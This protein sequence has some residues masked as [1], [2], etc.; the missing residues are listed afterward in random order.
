MDGMVLTLNKGLFQTLLDK[1]RYSRYLYYYALSVFI[2]IS[3]GVFSHA[4]IFFLFSQETK[5]D[6]IKM[7]SHYDPRSD[8]PRTSI[9]IESIIGGVL[10]AEST[11]T[12]VV[13]G[14]EV[15]NLE[16]T[17][18]G[19]LEGHWSFARAVIQIKGGPPSSTEL[20]IGESIGN[21]KLIY[22]GRNYIYYMENGA[23]VRMEVGQD[24]AQVQKPAE[25][26]TGGVIQ[27]VISREEVNKWLTGNANEIYKGA[28]WGPKVQ[29]GK[30]LGV[31]IKKLS[32][33]HV[34]YKLGARQGDLVEK[35]N[36][37]SLSDT[38]R[39][40]EIWKALKTANGAKIDLIRNGE[41]ISYDFKIQN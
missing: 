22:I 11:Q 33:S 27:K 6:K 29:D 23:K 9:Q 5:N 35:I 1:L 16:F 38:E 14:G 32:P 17:L 3:M 8:A 24:T 10:F 21:R 37:Y 4:L 15:Q 40:F 41:K 20:A 26:A 7:F 2:G 31:E 30:V 25:T 34:F 36:G 12:P 39:M 19:T 13:E 18:L 28:A